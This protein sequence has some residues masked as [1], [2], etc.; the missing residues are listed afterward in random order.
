MTGKREKAT[1][2]IF[3]IM[4]NNLN[5]AKSIHCGLES[6]RQNEKIGSYKVFLNLKWTGRKQRLGKAK[7]LCTEE[8]EGFTLQIL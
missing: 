5:F 7:E 8:T 1:V 4:K 2:N 3:L 6:A